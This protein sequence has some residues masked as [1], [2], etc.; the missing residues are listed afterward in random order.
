MPRSSF[1]SWLRL[2][3]K[4]PTLPRQLF[5][6]L[7]LLILEPIHFSAYDSA[8][9]HLPSGQVDFPYYS[10]VDHLIVTNDTAMVETMQTCFSVFLATF[11]RFDVRPI[12]VYHLRHML[13]MNQLCR[14]YTHLRLP[15]T[16]CV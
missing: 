6:I 10:A 8:R 13:R 1:V 15:N 3:L 7:P 16:S 4:L 11:A 12:A 5:S 14:T 9:Q 2:I